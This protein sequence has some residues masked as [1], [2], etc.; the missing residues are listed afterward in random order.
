MKIFNIPYMALILLVAVSLF[1]FKEAHTNFPKN[2]HL[3]SLK[4]DVFQAQMKTL[5]LLKAMPE[6]HYDFKPSNSLLAFNDRAHEIVHEAEFLI[7]KINPKDESLVP[8]HEY[9]TE[10][11]ELIQLASRSFQVMNEQIEKSSND[12]VLAN[13]LFTFL[14]ENNRHR[15]QMEVYLT[16]KDI[17]Y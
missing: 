11:D 6:E 5:D 15:A 9:L 4:K 10:K 2:T 12:S 17:N 14:Q 3:S 7:V 13:E 8:D 1:A 16:L